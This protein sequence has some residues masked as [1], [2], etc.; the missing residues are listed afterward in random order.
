MKAT[1]PTPSGKKLSPRAY[2][3]RVSRL[4]DPPPCKHGHFGCAAWDDGPCTDELF[5]EHG[6][7]ECGEIDCEGDCE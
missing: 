3:D 5:A 7:A 6:C 4:K 2:V 1:I